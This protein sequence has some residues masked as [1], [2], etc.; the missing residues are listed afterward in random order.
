MTSIMDSRSPELK[1]I[2]YYWK[3]TVDAHYDHVKRIEEE[4]W[5]KQLDSRNRSLVNKGQRTIR[6]DGPRGIGKTTLAASFY[7]H[8]KKIG[9]KA[10]IIRHNR[11]PNAK[12]VEILSSVPSQ[13]VGIVGDIM[14]YAK[15]YDVVIIDDYGLLG[16]KILPIFDI[17]KGTQLIL[18]G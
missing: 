16:D 8:Y 12:D 4:D 3:E 6:F 9:K 14:F 15:P 5:V 13:D 18:L 10:A 7:F 2:V 17:F 11:E 1:N